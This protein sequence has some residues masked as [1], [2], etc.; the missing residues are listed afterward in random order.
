MS[1]K[2]G[3]KGQIVIEKSIRV[4][5]GIE[6]GYLAVQQ[7]VGERVEI[8]FFPPDHEHSLRGILAGEREAEIGT[9]ADSWLE[10]RDQAW[11]RAGL[12]A[13]G[14]PEDD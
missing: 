10:A 1:T 6:P 9:D 14:T 12:V 2:V 5:L 7:V 13:E 8:R 4:R 3:T 11:R